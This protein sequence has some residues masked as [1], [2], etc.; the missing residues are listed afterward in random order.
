VADVAPTA[1]EPL[2]EGSLM[3]MIK[4]ERAGYLDVF[5]EQDWRAASEVVIEIAR[6]D[7]P[8]VLANVRS[9]ADKLLSLWGPEGRNRIR[10]A[11]PVITRRWE[12]EALKEKVRRLREAGWNRWELGNLSGWRF[13]GLNAAGPSGGARST[14][15]I[16]VDWSVYVI[17]RAAALQVLDMGASQFTLSPE[18]GLENMQWL[19]REFG[20]RATVIAY[21]DTPLFIS[22]A[23]TRPRRKHGCDGA[24]RCADGMAEVQSSRGQSVLVV[25]R[26][27]R[28]FVLSKRPFCL[29]GRIP[30]LREAGAMSLRADFMYRAYTAAQ[31]RALWRDLR[32]GR[33]VP[34]SHVANFDGGLL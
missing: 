17:N 19:L 12:A 20:G 23:C 7:L 26:D 13:L 16:G 32:A 5:E 31:V 1:R 9:T 28:T 2:G 11:L 27:C 29:A 18:D 3:W 10:L 6:D 21:Q 33:P 8:S 4:V 25:T 24:E 30:Q 22:E 14:V 34:E 15:D